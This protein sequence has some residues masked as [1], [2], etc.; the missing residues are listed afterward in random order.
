MWDIKTGDC[1][2]IFAGYW[3]ITQIVVTPDGR[4]VVFGD[5][6]NSIKILD[7]QKGYC[8]GTLKGHED[9]V[10]HITITP[11]GTRILSY[12]GISDPTIRVWDI[13]SGAFLCVYHTNANVSSLSVILADGR[14]AFGS[15]SGE[16]IIMKPLNLFSGLPRITGIRQWHY[17]TGGSGL[18][19]KNRQSGYW[20]RDITV[21]C[22]WCG[23]NFPV[24]TSVLKTIQDIS[25][26]TKINSDP[27]SCLELPAEACEDPRLASE[28]PHC[29]KPLRYNP[30]VVDNSNKD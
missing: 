14:F 6:D 30:F 3:K 13:K 7:L 22:L 23:L 8:S 24:E 17:G 20:E 1:L 27:A 15:T 10:R 28:C 29:H 5:T 19:N 4:K 18:F 16:V 25:G 21:W 26:S 9:P 11:D 2:K 12:A